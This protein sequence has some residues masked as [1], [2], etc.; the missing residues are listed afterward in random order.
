ML[1]EEHVQWCDQLGV[2]YTSYK[3]WYKELPLCTDF[4]IYPGFVNSH[5]VLDFHQLGNLM[6]L[7]WPI[8]PEHIFTNPASHKQHLDLI[9]VLYS[10]VSVRLIEW[11]DVLLRSFSGS[12]IDALGSLCSAHIQYEKQFWTNIWPKTPIYSITIYDSYMQYRQRRRPVL[13]GKGIFTLK[14]KHI[15]HSHTH[16][17]GK[18]RR[19]NICTIKH[20]SLGLLMKEMASKYD[21]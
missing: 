11:V 21:G 3:K 15:T 12:H 6:S 4:E 20:P 1:Y 10:S 7:Q 13:Q 16:K 9:L 5:R 14:H 17:R 19:A 2:I 18:R 8:N